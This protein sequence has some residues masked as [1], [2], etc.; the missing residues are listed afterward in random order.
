[1]NLENL[2]DQIRWYVAHGLM[3]QDL[4]VGKVVDLSFLK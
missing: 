3:P 2:A 4:R 1:M